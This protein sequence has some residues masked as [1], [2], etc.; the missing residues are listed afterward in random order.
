LIRVIDT[1]GP[2]T[3][4]P[5]VAACHLASSLRADLRAILLELGRDPI[6][7]RELAHGFIE[8]FEPIDDSSY[9][10][11]REMLDATEAAGFLT[12]R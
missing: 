1:L 8:R 4:Q 11:L 5:I 6:S 10:D 12:L 3:I 2:S 7:R 9:D